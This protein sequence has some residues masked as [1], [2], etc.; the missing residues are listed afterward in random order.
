MQHIVISHLCIILYKLLSLLY[1]C[2]ANLKKYIKENNVLFFN[3]ISLNHI[4]QKIN[5]TITHDYI[6]MLAII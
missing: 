3:Q 6:T 5:L 2:I 4:S 1:K